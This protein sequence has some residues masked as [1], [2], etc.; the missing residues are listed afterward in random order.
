MQRKALSLPSMSILKKIDYS[1][2]PRNTKNGI[3]IGGNPFLPESSGEMLFIQSKVDTI[4]SIRDKEYSVVCV[5]GEGETSMRNVNDLRNLILQFAIRPTDL[6]EEEL[7]P[8][9]PSGINHLIGP[10]KVIEL[11]AYGRQI[12][13]DGGDNP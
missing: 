8:L 5:I 2:M 3:M 6:T 1:L 4:Y 7:K 11:F 9:I 13:W 10:Y 12:W